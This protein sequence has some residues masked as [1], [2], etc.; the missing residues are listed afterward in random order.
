MA[1]PLF[2]PD[3]NWF[4]STVA[5]S[6][7]AIVAIAGGFLISKVITI[8][9][10]R[11]AMKAEVRHTLNQIEALK[12]RKKHLGTP[13]NASGENV[14]QKYERM[15]DK[16]NVRNDHL[17]EQ[18]ASRDYVSDIIWSSVALGFLTMAGVVVPIWL[19]PTTPA[20]FTTMKPW[21]FAA[22]ALGVA[23]VGVVVFR[24]VRRIP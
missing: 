12:E 10:E 19:L 14:H 21:I 11:G 6:A 24:A 20:A 2:S 7:A 13:V 15:I 18:L 16:L 9:S 4:L 17:G 3:P 22:F 8:S 1:P 23:L 5:Q